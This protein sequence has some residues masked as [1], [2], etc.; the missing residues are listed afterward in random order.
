MTIWGY[1]SEATCCLSIFFPM[2][3]A[4]LEIT[5]QVL[6]KYSEV[7]ESSKASEQALGKSKWQMQMAELP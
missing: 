3:A 2:F 7:T 6:S 1:V 5:A 4:F